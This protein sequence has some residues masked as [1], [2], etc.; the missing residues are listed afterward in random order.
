MNEG[1][2][3]LFFNKDVKYSLRNKKHVRETLRR[4]FSDFGCN[5]SFLNYIFCNDEFLY[6]MNV[7]ILN[8]DT[9]TDIIT[10]D[11]SEG[12]EIKGEAYISIDRL[13]DNAKIFK[14]SLYK[15]TLRV[16]IHGALHLVGLNDKSEYEKSEMRKK[17]DYYLR[18][19]FRSF[20]ASS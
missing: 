8:H 5:L 1:A 19:F 13:R 9:L 20:T 7:Q 4:I 6:N 11:Y 2:V 16:I 3:I 18:E 15:E 10:L 14:T 12:G 17:E